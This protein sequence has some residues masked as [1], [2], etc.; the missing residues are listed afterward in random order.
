M[1]SRATQVYIVE[2]IKKTEPERSEKTSDP[3][4][5]I[6][7][8]LDDFGP[9]ARFTEQNNPKEALYYDFR[10]ARTNLPRPN[11]LVGSVLHMLTFGL[12]A[13]F[14]NMHVAYRESGIWTGLVLNVLLAVLVGYCSCILVWSAQKMYGRVQVPVLSYQDLAE[15]TLL[16]S[17]CQSVRRFARAFRHLVELT[18]ALH[19]IGSCCVFV[20]MI[21]RNLKELVEGTGC[22]SDEGDPPLTVY[23][24]SL[25]I[26]CTAVCMVTNLKHLAPF[27]IIANFYAGAV[28]LCTM[29]YCFKYARKSPLDRKGYKNVMGVFEFIGICVFASETTSI[30]LP[31][32]NNMNN[33]REFH[34]VILLT[35]P[36]LT[37]MTMAIGFFGVWH[38][39]DNS[40]P[41]ILIHF[42]YKPFPIQLKVFLCL[43]V[44]VIY[45]TTF[46]VGFDILWF[47]LRKMHLATRYR[48]YERLYRTILVCVVTAISYSFPNIRR[49]MGIV[50]SSCT[51]PFL[52]LYPPFIELIIDWAYPGLGQH[53][54]R[55]LKFLCLFTLG[56]IITIGGT[57]YNVLIA[58]I[59]VSQGHVHVFDPDEM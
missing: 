26:P 56:I 21:A 51:A 23:I 15:A 1:K 6:P 59:E 50:G 53:R 44:Y 14:H 41:P 12:G 52:F 4:M 54:W 22:L 47:Y 58:F 24:I 42:P 40:I 13:G 30:A 28:L 38:Y 20:V 25:V 43:M 7:A 17:P 55:L 31:I 8:Q 27:A 9:P 2:D 3:V 11:G 10:A 5:T 16:L 32:E 57:Y 18:I 48:L 49:I 35:M 19:C 46:H 37:S 29:W 33:P 45:A 39:G 34:R 36:I